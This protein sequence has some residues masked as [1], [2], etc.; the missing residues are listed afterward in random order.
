MRLFFRC[1]LCFLRRF[2]LRSL[3]LSLGGLC[4]RSLGG[5]LLRS[6]GRL[7]LGSFSSRFFGSSGSFC[8]GS[9]RGRL[10][11]SRRIAASRPTA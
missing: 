8:F 6:L 3:L 7:C 11:S 9:L 10:L 1:F 2:L 4:L 5:R